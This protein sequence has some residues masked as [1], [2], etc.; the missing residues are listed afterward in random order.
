MRRSLF[1]LFS[2]LPLLLV[3]G[4]VEL[5]LSYQFNQ[6]QQQF[7]NAYESRDRCTRASQNPVL[8]Y[9]GKPGKCGA[10]RLGYRDK[11]IPLVKQ[12]DVFRIVIIGDSVAAGQRV[13]RRESFGHLLRQ[14]L[15]QHNTSEQSYEVFV[16]AMSGYSTSQELVV[17]KQQALALEPDP[18]FW[19]YVLNDPAHPV[20]H[21]AN[22]HLG[23][24]FYKP[25]SHIPHFFSNR[26]FFLWEKLLRKQC[27]ETEYH[28]LLHCVYRSQVID[29]FSDLA[30]TAERHKIPIWLGIH[31][32]IVNFENYRYQQI[33]DFISEQALQHSFR[34]LDFLE[35]YQEYNLKDLQVD[36]FDTWHP[37]SLGHRLIYETILLEFRKHYL[38]SG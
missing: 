24:Y 5:S 6:W 26:F 29:H 30:A 32:N 28:H 17:L 35:V 9:E 2:F 25:R 14:S 20:F 36:K 33:H 27:S 11:E 34:V 22:G 8:I 16:L 10:N 13:K 4:I 1:W 7:I 19:S 21:N 37:N 12:D 18:I 15:Q 23:A 38:S 31:P 3:L